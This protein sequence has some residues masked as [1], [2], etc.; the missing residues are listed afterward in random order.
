MTKNNK[1]PEVDGNLAEVFRYGGAELAEALNRIV[2]EC[3]ETEPEA[4][5]DD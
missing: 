1:S 2:Q 3:W 5:A 4:M